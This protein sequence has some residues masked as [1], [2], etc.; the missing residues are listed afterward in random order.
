MKKVAGMGKPA[1]LCLIAMGFMAGSGFATTTYYYT[2][3]PFNDFRNGG[4]CPPT[5]NITGSFTVA[6]PLAPDL[7]LTLITPVSFSLSAGLTT[8]VDGDP[9]NTS[10]EVSTDA[11]G[12]ISTWSWV[13]LGPEASIAARILTQDLPGLV[14]DS[15]HF[16]DNAPPF[17][18]FAGPLAAEVLNDPGTWSE[19]PEPSYPIS[20]GVAVL[21]VIREIR[22]RRSA[23]GDCPGE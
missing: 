3:N 14:F 10:L 17:Q 8:L 5:C 11:F 4:T 12:A 16:G 18:G 2:G 20:V 15:V 9:A 19:T 7:P 23:Q 1:L 22:K 21:L 13:V 6:T